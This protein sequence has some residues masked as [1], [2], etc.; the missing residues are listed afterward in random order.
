M[1]TYSFVMLSISACT[2]CW[3]KAF[4]RACTKLTVLHAVLSILASCSSHLSTYIK[5]IDRPRDFCA[6]SIFR[7]LSLR[8]NCTHAAVAGTRAS[9]TV[10]VGSPLRE[11]Q[12][13]LLLP[14]T[15]W[16]D[17]GAVSTRPM[18]AFATGPHT[19]VR[20]VK[21]RPHVELSEIRIGDDRLMLL[22]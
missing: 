20:N 10:H 17:V 22:C 7:S 15:L 4:I 11:G 2:F 21:A 3:I 19:L 14:T 8:A 5:R 16:G 6:Y 9:P 18:S 12:A 1:F 13:S